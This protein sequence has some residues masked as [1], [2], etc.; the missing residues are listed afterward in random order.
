MKS[1]QTSSWQNLSSK[2]DSCHTL[3]EVW[4]KSVSPPSSI[5]N[6]QVSDSIVVGHITTML[7]SRGLSRIYEQYMQLKFGL[8]TF[9]C[10][11]F[12]FLIFEDLSYK[13]IIY[14]GN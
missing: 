10:V 11:L 9:L 3:F 13:V 2:I 12:K 14:Y 8:L 7:I 6:F 5:Y 1:M 4:C